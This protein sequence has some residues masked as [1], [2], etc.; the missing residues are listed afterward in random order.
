MNS[1]DCAPVNQQSNACE[2]VTESS[3]PPRRGG[4]CVYFWYLFTPYCVV[5][6]P[7][8]LLDLLMSLFGSAA[9]L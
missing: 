9:Q 4:R 2:T 1:V 6:L 3:L 7:V 8:R 5:F